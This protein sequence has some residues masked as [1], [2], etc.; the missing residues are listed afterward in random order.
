MRRSFP[1]VL[2]VAALLALVG[3]DEES[4]TLATGSPSTLTVRAYVDTNGDG[5][6]TAG[7][8][9]PIASVTI[10]ATSTSGGAGG[11]ATTG[12]EGQATLEGLLPG[13]Y[14]VQF[15]GTMPTGSALSTAA[16]PVVVAPFRGAALET[17]FRF[18]WFPASITGR[19]FRDDDDSG[20]FD[21]AADLPAAGIGM[22]LYAGSTATGTPI[23][24]LQTSA[25][26]AYA[27]MGLRPGTYTVEVDA[28]ETMEIV[29]G[30]TQTLMLAPEQAASLP[31][32]F[33]GTL[34]VDVADARAA[35]DGQTVTI[36]GVVTWQAQWDSRSYF[37]QDGTAGINVFDFDGPDLQ[38]GE[39]IEITGT[40][41]AFR[42]ELQVSPVVA[43]E[44]F[45]DV[46]EPTPRAVTGDEINAGMFQGELVTID[47]I[48][49][50]VDLVNNFG[51]HVV[52]V[53]DGAGTT[54]SIYVDNRTG[55]DAGDW[56]VGSTYG[57]TG[58]LGFD[59]R[60]ALPSRLEV[61][62][63]EDLQLGGSALSI[64]D[65]RTRDGESVVIQGVIS[66]QAN[67]DDRVFF[68][69]DATGG[70][71][72]FFGGAE[73]LQRGDVVQI[74]GTIGAFR[75]EVQMSPQSVTVVGSGPAPSPRGVTGAEIN[76][77]SFQGEL[78]T[79]TG[80]L[81]SVNVLSFD[82]Q[83]VT[84]R[85]AAGTE[86]SVYV[87]SRTGL[88]SG[89]WPAPGATVRV[90]G[91][92]GND[93]R[94]DPAA[95]VEARG[96]EDLVVATAGQI[97]VAEAR[98]M[99][100]MTVTI[101]AVV[102]WQTSWDSRVYFFQDGTGGMSAFQNGAPNLNRGDRVRIT[103]TVGSFR[104]EVQ[105][106]PDVVTVIGGGPPLAPR[107]VPAAAVNAGLYQGE[108]VQVSGTLVNVET[109]SFDNQEVTVRDAAGGMATIYVDSRNGVLPAAWPAPGASVT[110]TG[111]LG[112]DDRLDQP[113]R[114]ELRDAADL[115]VGG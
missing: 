84:I 98:S 62:F 52:T 30:T 106:S 32:L 79:V 69:Q 40:R 68:L 82:N 108:L 115:Q 21:P 90:T 109:L 48:V 81:V 72:V 112:T 25:D 97:S 58:V 61:R 1:R 3:C 65:A 43:L 85:D 105:M 95:R 54:F 28:L 66:W 57:L 80:E 60:D 101:E 6:W 104:S 20:D 64:A 42:G 86:F 4:I 9:E 47:G 83:D 50:A 19:L 89:A 103:G 33:T 111:T 110:V 74:R 26:G 38:I 39:E 37:L 13:S 59:E 45:G 34:R 15:G 96:T 7:V 14:E 46:G 18:T 10:T 36:R 73:A 88:G 51:T 100:G 99:D 67:W 41:G 11:D 53:T 71:S 12:A 31:V 77:G 24:T 91:V 87:D 23:A 35:A 44:N 27:F 113:Y 94:N 76:A 16:N 49:Q 29:G 2:A 93:D 107:V 8:D 22:A 114:I 55:V 92:I 75:G 56:S 5:V 78:V 102:T 70:I 17:E 63:A